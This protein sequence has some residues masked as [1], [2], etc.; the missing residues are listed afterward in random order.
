MDAS[1]WTLHEGDSLAWLATL[2]TGH[3]DAL[4][5]DPPYSS[6]GQFRSDRATGSTI[7]YAQSSYSGASLPDFSGDNRDGHGFA[8]WATLWLSEAHRV[9]RPGGVVCLFTDWRQLPTMT[10]VLQAGGWVWRGINVWAK[11]AHRAR[12]QQGRFRNQAEFIV[13]GSHGRMP[14]GGAVHP[15][16][17]EGVAPVGE[18]RSHPT[19]K[20]LT[21]MRDLVRIVPPGGLVLDPF[22]GSGTTGLAALLE[23]RRFAGCEITPHYAALARQRLATAAG[24][25]LP[26]TAGQGLLELPDAV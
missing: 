10:D 14:S 21:V 9:V 18:G 12:P 22:A 1:P 26:A 2:P 15:G 25:T 6:G 23:G 17:H 5:T 13:W 8:L 3:A 11:P 19:E 4:V 7:K 16:L 20:P 24:D